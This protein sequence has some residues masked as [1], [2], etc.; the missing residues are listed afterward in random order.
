M[1][2]AILLEIIEEAIWAPTGDN[3][4]AWRFIVKDNSLVVQIDKEKA[5]HPIDPHYHAMMISLGGY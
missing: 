1:Q 3:M 2:P 4:Q 5:Y